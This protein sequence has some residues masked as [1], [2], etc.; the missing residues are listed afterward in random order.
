MRSPRR[1][2]FV[3]AFALLAIA[4]PTCLPAAEEPRS[5]PTETEIAAAIERVAAD[6]NLAGEEKHRVLRWSSSSDAKPPSSPGWFRWIGELFSWLAQTSRVLVWLVLI[7]LAG[8]LVLA[9][10]RVIQN[11]RGTGARQRRLDV[12]TH[13]RELDIR[14]ESL[15]D[16]IGK[17]ALAHWEAG[18]RRAALS[19][20]YRG[21]LSRLV[22]VHSVPI[23]ESTTEGDCVA[24]AARHLQS[25]R[26]SYVSRLV[27]T[28]QHAVYGAHEPET[29][30]VRL[31]CDGFA[32]A[33]APTTQQPP[34]VQA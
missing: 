5:V 11:A 26:T 18:E 31:L 6:P 27:R 17:A 24:L 13:V 16:D 29:T 9:I 30:A 14:P 28:W 21:L 19:L 15:P 1:L 12:P 10:V 7:V 34:E 2:W 8:L 4:H 20:L 23:R 32:S 3:A 33:L 22:H 25:D